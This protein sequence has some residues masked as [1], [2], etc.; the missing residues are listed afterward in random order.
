[1]MNQRLHD[2]Q[3]D[4]F[5][6]I[7]VGGSYAGLSA[8]MA[9]GRSRR[10]VLIIDGGSPC[11]RYA[12]HSHN[13][14]THDGSS[15]LAIAALARKQ[16]LAY[17]TIRFLEG[18]ATKA[19]GED[20]DFCMETA[21]GERFRTRKL[22]FATGIKD[23]MPDISGFA[24]CWGTSVIHCP[25][26]HGYEFRDQPTGILMNGDMAAHFAPIVG[27]LSNEVTIL[28]N[29]RSL[30][31]PEKRAALEAKGIRINEKEVE[32]I[33][34]ESGN[35]ASVLFKD[36]TSLRINALYARPAFEQHCAI[37]T[38][39]GCTLTELGYIL[40]NDFQQTNIPGIYA[41]G[42]NTVAMRSIAHAVA[43]GNKAGSLIN[44]ELIS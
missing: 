17:P 41:A 11:N 8:A 25:Y 38:A 43:A 44:H 32:A 36:A 2:D 4:T 1:M 15:P 14:L 37:P 23:V 35:I 33:R 22:L 39:M 31:D 26:C 6:V 13:F 7:I 29:G 21:A 5:D 30:I 3:G 10:N 12:E 40:V 28:T 20:N 42:D 9:L 24:E 18:L 34:H 27:N 19:S 16:V